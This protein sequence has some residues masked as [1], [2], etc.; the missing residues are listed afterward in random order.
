MTTRSVLPANGLNNGVVRLPWKSRG[1]ESFMGMD[2]GRR[3]G[4]SLLARSES[5]DDGPFVA[6]CV[7][8]RLF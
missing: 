2:G 1:G 5:S 3:P 6:C 7:S 8:S 4:R